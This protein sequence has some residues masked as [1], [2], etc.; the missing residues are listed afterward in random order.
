MSE[1]FSD[2]ERLKKESN[3]LRGTIKDDLSNNLTG[4]FL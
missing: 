2:N 4:G 1:K 3:L